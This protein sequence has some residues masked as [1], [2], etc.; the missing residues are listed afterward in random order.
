[1]ADLSARLAAV[2]GR[3][4]GRLAARPF[5]APQF[6]T[7]ID[8]PRIAAALD[9]GGTDAPADFTPAEREQFLDAAAFLGGLEKW[10]P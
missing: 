10:H 5:D 2:Q 9:A 4:A 7:L 6:L 3:L 8:T 1:M